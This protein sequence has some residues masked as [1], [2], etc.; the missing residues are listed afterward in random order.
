LVS[1]PWLSRPASLFLSF[2]LFP[3]L[4]RARACTRAVAERAAPLRWRARP[5]PAPQEQ[6]L[7]Q[8][9]TNVKSLKANQW[10]C[11]EN[12]L[13]LE[14]AAPFF[15]QAEQL[16]GGGGGG[17]GLS[18][19]SSREEG[20]LGSGIE[21]SVMGAAGGSSSSL[22]SVVGV[23]G[24]DKIGSFEKCARRFAPAPSPRT[25]SLARSLALSLFGRAPGVLA[26]ARHG[27][28][29]SAEAP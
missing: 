15:G 9:C 18:S 14:L 27:C 20:L 26:G 25:V 3:S 12:I 21:L 24:E 8:L 2:S 13:A 16:G 28:T 7:G 23:I 11:R 19:A 17:G 29:H 5:A 4:S 6:Y 10:A 22:T 1:S